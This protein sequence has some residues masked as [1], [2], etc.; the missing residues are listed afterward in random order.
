MS[1]AT[2]TEKYL[3]AA[4][5]AETARCEQ[6]EDRVAALEDT[7]RTLSRSDRDVA[8]MALFG[9]SPNEAAILSLLLARERVTHE[10]IYQMLFA[11]RPEAEHPADAMNLIKVFVHKMRRKLRARLGLARE[12]DP[13][14]SIWGRGYMIEARAKTHLRAMIEGEPAKNG[15]DGE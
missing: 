13:V 12:D 6:L 9:L 10:Q 2:K 4:L 15:G 8:L 11:H 3:V 5:A 7:V 1:V 14:L